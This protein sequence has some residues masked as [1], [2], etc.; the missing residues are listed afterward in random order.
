[1]HLGPPQASPSYVCRTTLW[2]TDGGSKAGR[3]P[4]S[5]VLCRGHRSLAFVG[6][7]QAEPKASAGALGK[8]AETWANTPVRRHAAAARG[9]EEAEPGGGHRPH[10][11]C[12]P[13]SEGSPTEGGARGPRLSSGMSPLASPE[14]QAGPPRTKPR[15][16]ACLYTHQRVV[17]GRRAVSRA[18]RSVLVPICRGEPEHLSGT[19][20]GGSP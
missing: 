5:G 1:M 12:W 17:R 16:Q 11:A 9:R 15:A 6:L 14:P 2:D 19:A 3:S 7:I 13:N 8:Q 10:P 18:N 4:C 20:A